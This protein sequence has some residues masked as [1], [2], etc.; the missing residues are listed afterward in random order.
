M[1]LAATTAWASSK[2]RFLTRNSTASRSR[3]NAAKSNGRHL[4][5][6][7]AEFA[8]VLPQ[9]R[10]ADCSRHGYHLFWFRLDPAVLGVAREAFLEALAAEGVPVSA[11][12]VLPLYRQP[13]FAEPARSG[14]IPVIAWH[15]L[16]STIAR[17]A[18]LIAKRFAPPRAPGWSSACSWARTTT[19]R[20][21]H[22]PSKKCTPTAAG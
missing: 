8:G 4:A 19:W 6:R 17:F 13:L 14:R 1:S 15:G 10:D 11:G 22:A 18:A 5:R 7:L 3:L 9:V 21:S 16:I 12:Y 20:T 2:G